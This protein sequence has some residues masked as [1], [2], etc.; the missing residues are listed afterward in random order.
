MPADAREWLGQPALA[1]LW[2]AAGR[3]LEANGLLTRGS[4]R[5]RAVSHEERDAL[6][7]LLGRVP[8]GRGVD[9]VVAL[10]VLDAR[11]RSSAAGSGLVDVLAALGRPVTDRAGA[12]EAG[13]HAWVRVWADAAG[14]LRRHGL[15]GAAP[16]ATGWA[17]AWL[18]ATRRSG[19]LGRLEATAAGEVLR[20]AVGVL[21]VLRPSPD[22]WMVGGAGGDRP[23]TGRG[24][25]AE[26]V[27][28][29]AHGLDEGT[30]LARLVL[31]ALALAVG[32]DPGEMTRDAAARRA[33]W[34]TCGVVVDEV[35]S[36]VL[37]YGLRP[38]GVG[39]RERALTVRADHA[40]ETH[41][42]LRE[43]RLLSW[44][45]TPGTLVAVCENPRVLEAAAEAAAPAALVCTAGTPTTVVLE[46]LDRLASGGAGFAYHGDFDW[47]G[48]ALANRLIGRF[49]ASPWRMS[50]ADYEAAVAACRDRGSPLLP[51]AGPPVDAC[52]DPELAAAMR[53]LGVG[54]HEESVLERLLA[55]LACWPPEN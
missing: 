26:R 18:D 2:D 33:L 46:L 31:R 27:T 15:T 7:L 16:E 32:A 30:L 8:G 42:T 28:G 24:D 17:E 48:V 51:L 23:G 36:T 6:A 14:D 43:T 44:R 39:W 40:A 34:R 22:V 12:R 11:L 29:S 45:V 53:A 1:R 52:W 9:V 47:P 35:S 50:A 25:L 38:L 19:S 55:D 21:A 5:L 13:R 49:G 37:T 54:V 4:L 41:L 20:Q 10:D 3:R